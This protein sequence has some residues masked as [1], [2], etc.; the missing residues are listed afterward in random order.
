MFRRAA[1]GSCVLMLVLAAGCARDD[2]YYEV[3]REQRANLKDITDLLATVKDE[4]SM[5]QAKAAFAEKA[6]KYEAIARKAKALPSPPPPAVMKRFQEDRSLLESRLLLLQRE[7]ARVRKLPGGE[8]FLKQFDS[9]SPGLFSAV[10][11]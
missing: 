4:Q 5:A 8:E 10:R 9:N 6:Q 11:Q 1:K 7:V 3:F 2:D